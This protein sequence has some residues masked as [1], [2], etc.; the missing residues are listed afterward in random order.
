ME[1][2]DSE[3]DVIT[4]TLLVKKKDP[5]NHTELLM[6]QKG[7]N[8]WFVEKVTEAEWRKSLSLCQQRILSDNP[9]AFE[10]IEEECKL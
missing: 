5:F 2:K 8:W 4:Y 3:G 10:E 6:E 7:K 1:Y 9:F